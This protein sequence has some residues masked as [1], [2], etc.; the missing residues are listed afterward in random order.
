MTRAGIFTHS[1]LHD[2]IANV[3]GC[4]DG[5]ILC[6]PLQ[7]MISYYLDEI[8]IKTDLPDVYQ[9]QPFECVVFHSASL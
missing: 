2:Q 7:H 6:F 3:D 5:F 1:F 9:E 8:V 4:T